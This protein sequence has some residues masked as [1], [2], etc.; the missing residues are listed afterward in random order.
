MGQKGWLT[1]HKSIAQVRQAIFMAK[2]T[3]LYTCMCRLIGDLGQMRHSLEKG[4][5]RFDGLA[6]QSSK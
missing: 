6:E 5:L 2:N 1:N 3:K 4:E